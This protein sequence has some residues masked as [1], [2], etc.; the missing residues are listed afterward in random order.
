MLR[1]LG[2]VPIKGKAD[3]IAVAEVQWETG[4]AGSGTLWPMD[5]AAGGGVAKCKDLVLVHH[6]RKWLFD[7]SVQ[8]VSLGRHPTC[9]LVI[10]DR[11]ASRNQAVIER[12]NPNWVIVDHSTNGTHVVFA[13]GDDVHLHHSELILHGKG[14]LA[15]GPSDDEAEPEV[16]KFSLK[17]RPA[18]TG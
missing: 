3:G 7:E 4:P 18:I 8:T 5:R 14:H 10:E 1:S 11:R 2:R 13:S 12:R 15:F 6:G 9:D 16:V 17:N